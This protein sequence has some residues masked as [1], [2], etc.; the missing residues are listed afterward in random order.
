MNSSREASQGEKIQ[1]AP[2]NPLIYTYHPHSLSA[3]SS[4][5]YDNA[6]TLHIFALIQSKMTQ[7]TGSPKV[8]LKRGSDAL[9]ILFARPA[10]HYPRPPLRY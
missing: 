6:D 1:E 3:T 10:H 7:A 4:S 9:Y 5:V 2:D 8:F